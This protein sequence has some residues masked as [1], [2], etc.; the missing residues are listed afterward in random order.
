MQLTGHHNYNGSGASG[1]VG[2]RALDVSPDGTRAIVVGNFK[3]ADGVQ[4]D[5]IVML[6]LSPA[7]A[8]VDANWNTLQ[9]TAACASGAFD[10]Y[11]E[12]VQFS[13]D[14]S[15]FVVVATGG[16]TFSSNTDGTRAL[17]D[18]A[19]RWETTGHRHATSS[20]PGS[21]TPAT[22]RSGRSP[23]PARP[24]TSAGTSAG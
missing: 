11:V 10:T 3:N 21:T 23:S 5:Q 17:C 9:Y 19:T 14:G 24:S 6:D 12:D 20:R 4:H 16:G 1:P 13:P 15:Y 18:S 8:V 2:G 22:T 7:G